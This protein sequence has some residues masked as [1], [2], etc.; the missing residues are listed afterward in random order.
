M[1]VAKQ[2]GKLKKNIITL[3]ILIISGAMVYALPY[4]RSYYY[5]AFVECFNLTDTQMG[6]LGKRIRKLCGDRLLPGR[7]LCRPLAG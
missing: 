7:L 4:F 5:D 2:E 1:A 6:A 3:L